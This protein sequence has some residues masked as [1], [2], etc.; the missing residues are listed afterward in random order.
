MLPVAGK[1]E[2]PATER[3]PGK[4]P[5]DPQLP[6]LERVDGATADEPSPQRSI[7]GGDPSLTFRGRTSTLVDGKVEVETV[8]PI[9]EGV[10]PSLLIRTFVKPY[11]EKSR[12]LV[13]VLEGRSDRRSDHRRFL[14]FMFFRNSTKDLPMHQHPSR[15]ALLLSAMMTLGWSDST[16]SQN[17]GAS[18]GSASEWTQWRGPDRTGVS[19]ENRWS[20]E[21]KPESLWNRDVGLGYS[22]VAVRDGKLLTRGYQ[23]DSEQ[24]VTWCLDAE[25]GETLWEHRSPARL[26]D[27]MHTGGTLTTPVIEG[28]VVYVLSRLGPMTTLELDTGKVLW[29]R[30]LKE[31]FGAELGPFGYCASPVVIE[32]RVILNVGKTIALGKATG[33]TLWETEDYGVSY[34]T[35]TPFEWEGEDCLAVFNGAGLVVMGLEDGLPIAEHSWTSGYNVNAASP[36]VVDDQVFIST[37][38]NEIGCVMLRLGEEL[39]VVW[40]NKEMNSKMNGCVLFEDHL[41]GF[42]KS[43]L[44]CLDL[45][46]NEMWRERGL[47]MGTVVVAGDRLLVLSETGE[48]VIAEAS[49][50]AFEPK[51]RAQVLAGDGKCWTTPVLVG[52]VIYCRDSQGDLV[53]RDHRT[54]EVP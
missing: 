34:S 35:P 49:S 12:N 39:E 40:E 19:L 48:L 8:R 51:S 13:R 37:G 38:Y 29:T 36:I 16:P 24:D 26:W 32:D 1:D 21:G 6:R 11:L 45:E 2:L 22:A 44:K 52:G 20:S 53:A 28:N 10:R 5:P 18:K 9:E 4:N 46:G 31:D 15:V 30:N 7:A 3:R 17:A 54:A 33:E 43:I 14:S 50:E 47:G 41:F 25:T 23:S 27:N 42:D